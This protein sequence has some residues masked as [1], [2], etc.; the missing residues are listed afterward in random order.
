MSAAA[1]GHLIQLDGLRAL[2]VLGVLVSHYMHETPSLSFGGPWGVRLFFVL[3]GF[4]ITSILLDCREAM[5]SGR[6]GLAFTL[7]RF[8]IR[9]ALRIFPL[10]YATLLAAWLL[11][12]PEVRANGLW[13]AAYLSNIYF[14][15][16]ETWN[17]PLSHFWS[18]AVE[19]Q[20][21]LVWPLLI[22]LAPARLLLPSILLAIAAA[23]AFRW[24]GTAAGLHDM[25]LW[26][27]PFT[28]LDSLGLGAMLAA[29]SMRWPRAGGLDRGGRL[30]GA[31]VALLL[32]VAAMHVPWV[33][34]R[35][36]VQWLHDARLY[37][38]I[39]SLASAAVI[40]G[41]ARG[42]RGPVGRLLE[43]R[44]LVYVG[45]ISYGVYVLHLFMELVLPRL[46]A[47]AGLPFPH[48]QGWW[49]FLLLT[50][51]TIA[52]A[53]MSWHW[54]EKPINDLKARFPY[55]RPAACLAT[56]AAAA[57]RSAEC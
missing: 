56:P 43:W 50:A 29:S 13:H 18:L 46:F 38:T 51:G 16:T 30:A 3:S 20:F 48:E 23:P 34:Q 49:R 12:V 8:Y 35:P 27:L 52:A 41:A 57:V 2:A 45:R 7:R 26:N 22:L 33:A 32:L 47:G 17:F 36:P 25:M 1:R 28:A 37:E 40:L 6:Q 42:W 10:F 19:E 9:R 11:G 21:Y 24:I 39:V 15:I 14:A 5:E 4:L 31:T 55:R 54:F 53:A 44:L